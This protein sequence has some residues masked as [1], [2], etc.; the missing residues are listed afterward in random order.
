MPDYEAEVVSVDTGKTVETPEVKSEPQTEV[1][2]TVETKVEETVETTEKPEE[3][4]VEENL[5]ELPDGRKL[6]PKEAEVEYRN[7][8]SEF[9]RKSQKLAT[10]EKGPES[11]ETINKPTEKDEWIPQ[12][13]EEVK[14]EN[15]RFFKEELEKEKQAEIEARSQTETLVTGQLAELKKENP[16]LNET[17]LFNHALKYNFRDLKVAYSN[18]KDMQSSIKNATETTAKNIAKRNAEPISG[19][20]QGGAV[21]DGDIYDPGARN[22]SMVDYLRSLK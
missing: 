18:M 4:K 21:F 16:T 17:Q 3:T 1:E 14:K 11:K 9:T 10:Y 8:Y 22:M 6:P 2:E 19:G 7:L 13:W 15:Y 5:V 12:T 20:S